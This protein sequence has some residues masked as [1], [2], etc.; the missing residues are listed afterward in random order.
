MICPVL[1]S[2]ERTYGYLSLLPSGLD[3][4]RVLNSELV[5]VIHRDDAIRARSFYL[6]RTNFFC[7]DT[8]LIPIGTG[9]TLTNMSLQTFERSSWVRIPPAFKAVAKWSKANVFNIAL[10]TC[11]PG[12]G[13]MILS[14]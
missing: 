11:A 13:R 12:A 5:V 7:L 9:R 2:Q 1:Q 6:H 8:T 14:R 4:G 3:A 10:L